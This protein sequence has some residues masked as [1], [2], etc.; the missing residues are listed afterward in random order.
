MLGIKDG[1]FCIPL[2]YSPSLK[3]VKL[4]QAMDFHI[5]FHQRT[6]S[7]TCR[8]EPR[9]FHMP[10]MCPT[11]ELWPFPLTGHRNIKEER[12]RTINPRTRPKPTSCLPTAPPRNFLCALFD[13]CTP[14]PMHILTKQMCRVTERMLLSMHTGVVKA[15]KDTDG[16][17]TLDKT[18][19]GTSENFTYFL[20]LFLSFT[21]KIKEELELQNSEGNSGRRMSLLTTQR[22]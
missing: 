10:N 12:E 18:V 15:G 14:A 2:N 5:A 6:F 17:W 1:N 8:T 11:A 22:M 3:H 9:T 13:G 7:W 21:S 20:R 19:N 4:L 16:Q